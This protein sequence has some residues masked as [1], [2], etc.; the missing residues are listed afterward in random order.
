M[1]TLKRRGITA[2]TVMADKASKQFTRQ[3]KKLSNQQLEATPN[4]TKPLSK[5]DLSP[6]TPGSETASPEPKKLDFNA[7]P[8]HK[9]L[10]LIR[11]YRS[12]T[13]ITI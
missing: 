1:I 8:E 4:K 10:C 13:H 12:I 7:S 11:L 2:L 3:M 6:G 9:N 5:R